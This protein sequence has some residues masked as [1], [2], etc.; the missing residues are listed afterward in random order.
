MTTRSLLAVLALA[1]VSLFAASEA[2][3]DDAIV[4]VGGPIAQDGGRW[5]RAEDS[6]PAPV[7]R[8]RSSVRLMAGPV[9]IATKHGLGY[10]VGAG[11]EL[12]KNQIGVRFGG[13]WVQGDAAGG[14]GGGGSGGGDG[15]IGLYQAEVVLD[16]LKDGPFRPLVGLGAGFLHASRAEPGRSGGFAG[17]AT[18][19]MG[20]DYVFAMQDVDARVGTS[21]SGGILGPADDEVKDLRAFALMDVHLVIGF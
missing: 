11:L 4:T 19:R 7:E 9:G 16:V 13:T 15:S 21:V 1:S 3:A 20:F 8:Y 12:G 10:G 14:G 6:P 17:M 5:A 2:R 18:A